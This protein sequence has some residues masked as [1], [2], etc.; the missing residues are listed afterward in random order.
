MVGWECKSN[1]Q[2]FDSGSQSCRGSNLSQV[3][4]DMQFSRGDN[5]GAP[6]QQ[7]LPIDR[8]AEKSLQLTPTDHV[9]P[10]RCCNVLLLICDH[11]RCPCAAGQN[12]QAGQR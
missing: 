11:D 9:Q 3:R 6:R 5:I 1:R 4:V 12:D 2:V 10:I 8:A 7:S